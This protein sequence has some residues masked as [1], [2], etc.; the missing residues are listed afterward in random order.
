MSDGAFLGIVI[1]DGFLAQEIGNPSLA[2]E[3]TEDSE[4]ESLTRALP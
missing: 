4:S 2:S 1:G 3:G